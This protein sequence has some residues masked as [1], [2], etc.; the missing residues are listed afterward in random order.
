MSKLTDYVVFK[1]K[2]LEARYAN[3][4]I[5]IDTLFEAYFDGLVDI[6]GDIYE[7]LNNRYS[8]VKHQFTPA[9][10]RY[11]A[12]RFVPEVASHSKKLDEKL[13]RWH[14]DRGND[15]FAAFLGPRMVYTSGFFTDPSQTVEQA[16]DQ[17]MDMVCQKLQLKQGETMLDIGCGW[18]TL[19][20]H[21]A[22]YYGANT[23][24]VT[25]SKNQAEFGN[26]RIKEAGLSDRAR[27]LC[28]DYRDIP[29]TRYNKI[30]SLEMV[31]H[32]GVKNLTPFY[33][34]V[35]DLLDDDGLFFLQWTGLRRNSKMED[36]VWG[37]FMAKYIFQGAD[38]SL[39]LAPMVNV[40]EK[41]GWEIHSVENVSTHYEL[42]IKKWHDNWLSNKDEMIKAYGERWYRIWHVFLA[43]ATTIAGQGTAACFQVVSNKN[44]NE[45]DRDIWVG[46]TSLGERMKLPEREVRAES[47][48][49]SGGK[50]PQSTV[51]A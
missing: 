14:Y 7:L 39:P 36:L 10:V 32:V 44:L 22:K 6:P 26:A 1:D 24:G 19:A 23:T 28:M 46:Q 37:L 11:F 38:A 40:M 15:F 17:K 47:G 45:F 51:S 43:W 49:G 18:G 13:V 5:P 16:Q 29:K 2:K 8:V 34:Q 48:R 25:L 41:S 50:A 21:A 12:T 4:R 3:D 42:T 33:K 9:H 20:L 35:Y 30:S 31:E 27:I